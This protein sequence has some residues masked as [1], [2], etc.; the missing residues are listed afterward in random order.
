MSRFIHDVPGCTVVWFISVLLLPF[1]NEPGNFTGS[2]PLLHWQHSP[3]RGKFVS[4]IKWTST[5]S[6]WAICLIH[7][8]S[9]YCLKNSDIYI[10]L[11]FFSWVFFSQILLVCFEFGAKFQYFLL[12]HIWWIL[13]PFFTFVF[14]QFKNFDEIPAILFTFL[15]HSFGHFLSIFTKFIYFSIFDFTDSWYR[16]T[17][18]SL[19]SR[20]TIWPS[21]QKVFCL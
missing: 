13:N 9:D 7:A 10:F 2:N 11:P 21:F 12:L 18:R 17:I 16:K 8:T 1:H 19:R 14:L 15:D 20:W 4:N 5:H 6:K 3:F